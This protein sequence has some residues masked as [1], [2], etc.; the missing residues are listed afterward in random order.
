MENTDFDAFVPGWD[1]D[2][3]PTAEWPVETM[4]DLVS[5]VR[6]APEHTLR[7]LGVL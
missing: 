2:E 1:D 4:Q 7:V 3:D 5:E 6:G